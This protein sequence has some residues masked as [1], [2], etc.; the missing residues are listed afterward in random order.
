MHSAPAMLTVTVPDGVGAGGQFQAN[1]SSGPMLVTVPP[2]VRPGD[3]LQINT[4]A[5]AT[6]VTPMVMDR[7]ANLAPAEQ[8]FLQR[9]TR[10]SSVWK[11]VGGDGW[12]KIDVNNPLAKLTCGGGC[13]CA[14]WNACCDTGTTKPWDVTF[15][16]SGTSFQAKGQPV[17]FAAAQCRGAPTTSPCRARS[18]PARTNEGITCNL[19]GQR[20]IDVCNGIF[21]CM[22][23]QNVEG[24]IVFDTRNA[25]GNATAHVD[26][27]STLIG[28][29]CDGNP[30][31][32]PRFSFVTRMQT[33]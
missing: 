17:G 27:Y 18:L 7:L 33:Q 4:A 20:R 8:Q 31:K 3:T 30:A 25:Q 32:H 9:M 29:L 10:E 15:D 26:T 28:G 14:C 5:P 1:T 22:Q 2:G 23:A 16:P 13:C 21:W 12:M 6:G 24:T 11:S 19:S